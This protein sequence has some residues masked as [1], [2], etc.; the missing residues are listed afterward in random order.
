METLHHLTWWEGVPR[1]LGRGFNLRISVKCSIFPANLGVQFTVWE[2]ARGGW[3][4]EPGDR[5]VAGRE[6]GCYITTDLRRTR[7]RHQVLCRLS[8]P[9]STPCA[10][11]TKAPP[12]GWDRAVPSRVGGCGR[13]AVREPGLQTPGGAHRALPAGCTARPPASVSETAAVQDGWAS[14]VSS[15]CSSKALWI[16]G[17]LP[18][19]HLGGKKSTYRGRNSRQM[20]PHPHASAATACPGV[21]PPR[22]PRAVAPAGG[23]RLGSGPRG[24]RL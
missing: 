22:R 7:G 5:V 11:L 15:L 23:R 9:A 13:R 24:S 2:G 14:L 6:R 8:L 21:P 20:R 16:S 18:E 1:P 4:S 19:A 12:C 17:R 10:C 3:C